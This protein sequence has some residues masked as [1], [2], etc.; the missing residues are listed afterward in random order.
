[1]EITQERKGHILILTV[2]GRLDTSTSIRLEET[3]L[4]SIEGGEKQFVLDCSRLDYISSAG[5]RVLLLAVK[6]LKNVN[7]KIHLY[8]LKEQIKEV[9]EIAGFSAIFPF[10]DAQEDALKSLVQ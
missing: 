5:L 6:K 1:M 4:A 9:F 2:E 7:G 3:L 8:A 10:F